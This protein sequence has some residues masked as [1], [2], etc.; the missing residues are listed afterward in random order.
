MAAKH[1]H[2]PRSSAGYT[3]KK[4][5]FTTPEALAAEARAAVH[6]LADIMNT[7]KENGVRVIFNI[8]QFGESGLMAPQVEVLKEL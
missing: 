3:Y 4:V 8:G 1:T 7:G 5:K 6:K 2:A